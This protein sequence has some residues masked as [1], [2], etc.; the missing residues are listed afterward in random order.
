MRLSA[1]IPRR[2]LIL[3]GRFLSTV[4]PRHVP[5]QLLLRA[6]AETDAD[7]MAV[8]CQLQEERLDGMTFLATHLG[9]QGHL[10]ADVTVRHAR[11]VLW[12]EACRHG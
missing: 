5:I 6:A 10:R 4:A 2:K 3:Y 8:W 11:D 9:D 7:A 1:S 12:T